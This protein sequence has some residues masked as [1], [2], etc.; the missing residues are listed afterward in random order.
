ML[1]GI[2]FQEKK[3]NVYVKE[4]MI[5]IIGKYDPLLH[6]IKRCKLKWYRH[7]SRHDGLSKTIMQGIVED[8]RKHS[9]RRVNDSTI[10]LIELRLTRSNYCTKF[11]IAM[12]G[13]SVLLRQK[14]LN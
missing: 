8:S 12:A 11:T 10:Y 9:G 6:I 3:T 1:L 14:G 4:K 5:A 13:E 2:T 7:I